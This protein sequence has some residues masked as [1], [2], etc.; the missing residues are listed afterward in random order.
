MNPNAQAPQQPP[1]KLVDFNADLK[2]LCDKYQYE[3]RPVLSYEPQGTF[4]RLTVEDVSPKGVQLYQP[5]APIAPDPANPNPAPASP[6]KPVDEQPK[7]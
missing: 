3:L 1:Q 5:T 6:E 4:A 7:V 2:A